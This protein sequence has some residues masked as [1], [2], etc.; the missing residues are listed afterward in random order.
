MIHKTEVVVDLYIFELL[1]HD[2]DKKIEFLEIYQKDNMSLSVICLEKSKL[3][4]F[5][6]MA[7]IQ[8]LPFDYDWE[9]TLI[10]LWKSV[11]LLN[12]NNAIGSIIGDILKIDNLTIGYLENDYSLGCFDI[13]NKNDR[14]MININKE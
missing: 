1:N 5:Y 8:A 2:V 6:N 10:L 11:K 4:C 12:K 13:R 3:V 7:K 14:Y 9:G